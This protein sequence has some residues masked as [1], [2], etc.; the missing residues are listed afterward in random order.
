MNNEIV[1]LAPVILEEIKKAKRILLH[2]HPRPDGDSVGSSLAMMHV[3]EGMGKEVV[4][5]KGDSPLP[6]FLSS[7]PGFSKIV[8]KNFFEIDLSEFDLFLVQD[9]STIKFV[10]QLNDVVVPETLKVIVIDHHASNVG[11]GQINLLVPIYPAVCQ[12]LF[13]LFKEWGVTISTDTAKCLFV[14][15]YTDT[16]GFSYSNTLPSTL[17]VAGD[18]ATIAPDFSKIIFEM[19]NSSTRGQLI[20]EGL[21]LNSVRTFLGDKVAISAVSFADLKKNNIAVEDT[22]V[23]IANRLKSVPGWEIGISVLE[24]KEGQ[25]KISFRTRDS[26]KYDL[27]KIAVALGGGGHRAAAGVVLGLPLEEAVK[28]VVSTLGDIYQI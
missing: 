24:E 25:V 5:I 12:I 1:N 15:M 20:Y 27:T 26:E 14:G 6:Q 9:S 4:L 17:K 22:S 10:S 23:N 19:N 18:L 2:L 3:L 16:G 21:A 28:K 11:F 7:L 8:L 13:D